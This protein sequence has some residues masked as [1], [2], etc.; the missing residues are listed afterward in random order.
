MPAGRRGREYRL[1]GGR[2]PDEAVGQAKMA[3]CAAGE[4]MT[5][6]R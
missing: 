3:S 6:R 1:P 4:G 5:L 2:F